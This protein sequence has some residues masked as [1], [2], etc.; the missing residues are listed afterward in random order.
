MTKKFSDSFRHF[1]SV[2][3]SGKQTRRENQKSSKIT[4]CLAI[5]LTMVFAL[6]PAGDMMAKKTTRKTHSLPITERV[7]LESFPAWMKK[8]LSTLEW[9]A[10]EREKRLTSE[11]LQTS[12]HKGRQFMVNNQKTGGNFNYEYDFVKKSLNPGDNQ[13]RQ[14]GALW[15]MALMYQYEQNAENR[16]ALDRGL[17]FFFDHTRKG[18]VRGSLL[19]AYPGNPYCQ[20]GTVALTTLSIIEYLRT[21]KDG[22]AAIA[23]DYRKTLQKHLK[24]YIEFLKFM[25]LE[26]KHFSQGYDLRGNKGRRHKFSPYFDG[27][28]MLCLIKAAKYLGF[29]DLIPL[30]EDSAIVMA[31]YYTVDQWR[32]NLNAKQTK[33]FFQWSCMAF[34]EYQ[35]AG[36]KNA[37]T[38]GDYVLSLSWWMVHPR[39]V[40]KRKRNTAYAYEGIIHAY[41]VAKARNHEAALH[42]LGNVIDKGLFKL[43][44]WQVGG[45]LQSRNNF[46]GGHPTADPLAVGGVMNHKKEPFLRID[47]TQHQMHAVILA[48]RHVYSS[49]N[50]NQKSNDKPGQS[51]VDPERLKEAIR[52]SARYLLN[53]CH[54]D[55][56]FTYRINLDPAVVPKPKYNMLR[57]AGTI[58]ALATYKQTYPDENMGNIFD[59]SARFIREKSLGPVPERDDLLAVWSRPEVTRQRK[60]PQAKLGGTGLGLVALLNIEKIRPGTTSVDDLRKMGNFIVYMQKLDGSFYS[61][62]IPAKGGRDDSWTSLYYPGEAVLGLLMLHEKDPSPL[63]LRSA[64]DGMAY[65]ARIRSGKSVVKADHWALLATVRLMVLPELRE[66]AYLR[67]VFLQHAIQICESILAKKV[68]HPENSTEYG[69]FTGDGRVTPTA[70]MME[71]LLAAIS[72]LPQKNKALRERIISALHEGIR[73]L[74]R[75]QIRSGKY[76]GAIPRAIRPLRADH[77]KYKASFNARAGEVRIDY[78]QHA[79]SA[80][81]GYDLLF[82][83]SEKNQVP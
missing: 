1:G 48:L 82:G 16:K 68:Q 15:S 43:I 78:V 6:C 61:K 56:K 47:V 22:H 67:E 29:T 53:A 81:I 44:T 59:L 28:T 35:D 30:I 32:K 42:D 23:D 7:T 77:P 51:A 27:E 38:F 45:P 60:I 14:A 2:I 55:G 65:L 11:I 57:H 79:L 71:G 5:L 24:G 4:I 40:L 20:T 72:F 34:W 66:S 58:Y 41:Q 64:A 10:R 76:I 69:C 80:M 75:S 50:K 36:W 18:P 46:L 63:W 33:G 37:E 25:H 62:Y 8:H 70:T 54:D 26:N 73:F 49:K 39:K 19:I 13:V 21:E 12:F 74:L 83:N 31:K 3:I 52:L 9:D 17:K